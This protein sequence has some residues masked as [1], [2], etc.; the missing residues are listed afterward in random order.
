MPIPS[1]I[2]AGDTVI[3]D[4][5]AATDVL[6]NAIDSASYT[7][8]TYLRTNANHEGAIV[9]GVAINGVSHGT[10]WRSTIASAT[11]TNFDAGLWFFQSVAVAGTVK[12]TLAQGQF[13]VEASLVYSGQ[14]SAYDGRSQAQKDLD[15]VQAAMRAMISGGA[16]QRYTI[17]NRE[18]WKMSIADLMMLESKLKAEVARE[19]KADLIANGLGNPQKLFVRF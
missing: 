13:T 5:P 12:H 8:T 16:V 14:P 18:L 11:S 17:G 4:E 2:R 19:K 10:G 3:W 9:A 1:V 6:G 7:L 15:A